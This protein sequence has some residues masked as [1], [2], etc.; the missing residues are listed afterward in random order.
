MLRLRL[1]R[2]IV[3]GIA[4]ALMAAAAGAASA[5]LPAGQASAQPAPTI[6]LLPAS[7]PCDAPV[8]VRGRGFEPQGGPASLLL[9]L[10][11]PGTADV[12]MDSLNP[13]S[14]DADGAFSQRV[15]MRERGCEAVALDSEAERPSGYVVIAV[16][17]R[18]SDSPTGEGERIP[19]VIATA[20]YKYTTTAPH[21]PTEALS[22]VPPSGPCDATIEVRLSGFRPDWPV[23]IDVAGPYAH[24]LGLI[25]TVTT[26]ANG[27][28][29]GQVTLGEVGCQAASLD[30]LRDS[31]VSPTGRLV[32][33]AGLRPD[34][35]FVAARASYTYT[36]TESGGVPA[37]RTLPVT[38]E[39]PGGG[40]AD[41]FLLSVAM[42]L[43]AGG[44]MLVAA[45]LY[46]GRQLR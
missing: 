31:F 18:V 22:V 8:E 40:S 27:E 4:V 9:Y 45:S 42:V 14:P 11:Q 13:A 16:A 46:A 23:P 34:V 19:N 5:V 17:S 29:A 35:M 10:V 37:P 25:A 43:G 12:N 32:I 21:V 20:Q 15:A 39:G 6:E 33:F 1:A 28:F 7:G 44:L 41:S 26:D 3:L 2:Y 24:S 38:G 36:T 30:Q